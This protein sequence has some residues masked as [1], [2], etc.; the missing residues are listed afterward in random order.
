M[1]FPRAI[2]EFPE[3][4]LQ[5]KALIIEVD[6]LDGEDG[7]G[8]CFATNPYFAKFFQ[9]KSK[10]ISSALNKLV[11]E[12]WLI[13]KIDKVR[14]NKRRLFL[15]EKSSAILSPK[16]TLPPIP[17]NRIAPIPEN[18]GSY[19]RK[20]GEPI[21]RNIYSITDNTHIW[22]VFLNYWNTKKLLP[23]I[24]KLTGER[25][26]LLG[27][28]IEDSLFAEN[29]KGL[30]DKLAGSK[31]HTGRTSRSA[32][33]ADIDWFLK[34]Y[35]KIAELRSGEQN[36]IEGKKIANDELMKR[37][38]D[39]QRQ[40]WGPYLMARALAEL[41]AMKG[42]LNVPQWVLEKELKRRLENKV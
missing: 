19:P 22:V 36:R 26:A 7:T 15:T 31:F 24:S 21:N 27:K 5:Q 41:E 10:T 16:I 39:E 17:E 42:N 25:K 8:G 2:W 6:S 18:E 30:V 40:T 23:P 32:W 1:W 12:G 14:G 29:W 20:Q 4:S 33:V 28:A 35:Y 34:N 13:S 3:L 11:R 9:L 38:Q 37:R